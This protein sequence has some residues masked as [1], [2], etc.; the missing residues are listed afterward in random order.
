MVSAQNVVVAL[1]GQTPDAVVRAE[2]LSRNVL[3]VQIGSLAAYVPDQRVIR[4]MRRALR[5]AQ[6]LAR[7]EDLPEQSAVAAEPRWR[8]VSGWLRWQRGTGTGGWARASTAPGSAP[9]VGA[10]KGT[11]DGRFAVAPALEA[12]SAY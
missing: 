9:A 1:A 8:A 6:R 4:E 7:I 12:R 10:V 5:D 3:S 11:D 2:A